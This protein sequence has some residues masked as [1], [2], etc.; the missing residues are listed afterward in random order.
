MIKKL[1]IAINA[2]MPLLFLVMIAAFINIIIAVV[3]YRKTTNIAGIPET[4]Y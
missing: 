4:G 1:F 3:S 2:Y